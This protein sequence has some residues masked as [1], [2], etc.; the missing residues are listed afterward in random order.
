[1]FEVWEAETNWVDCSC[2]SKCTTLLLR[3]D[4]SA[5]ETAARKFEQAELISMEIQPE[6]KTCAYNNYE[7]SASSKVSF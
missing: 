7:Y 5:Y 4:I 2:G 3:E 1:M 6:T